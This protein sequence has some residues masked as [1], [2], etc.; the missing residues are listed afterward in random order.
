MHTMDIVQLR[1][2]LFCY[3]TAILTTERT[4]KIKKK[5]RREEQQGIIT[6]RNK[7]I[8]QNMFTF[9]NNTLFYKCSLG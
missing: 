4:E 9:K 2:L 8:A 5:E 1:P 6:Y 3:L 7:K